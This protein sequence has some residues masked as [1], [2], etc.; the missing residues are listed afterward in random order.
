[1]WLMA[2][3]VCAALMVSCGGGDKKSDNKKTEE[4]KEQQKDS[5]QVDSKQGETLQVEQVETAA[6]VATSSVEAKAKEFAN[7]V[8][9]AAMAQDEAAFNKV[10]AEA[11]AWFNSLSEAD[12]VVA[13]QV[14][15][16]AMSAAGLE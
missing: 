15:A 7:K 9:A 2:A 13:A 10:D 11:E 5:Q 8:I 12:Q 1:M 14:I 16:A 3:V 6:H 4:K